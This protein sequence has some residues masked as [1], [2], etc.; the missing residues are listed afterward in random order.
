MI[1]LYAIVITA[2]V[3]E[4]STKSMYPMIQLSYFRGV[5]ELCYCLQSFL[6]C[7]FKDKYC[8]SILGTGWP[9]GLLCKAK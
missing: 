7:T 9:E 5:T 2:G 1:T 8:D 3:R 6:R 4:N